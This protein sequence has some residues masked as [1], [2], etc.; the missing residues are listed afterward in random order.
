MC[1]VYICEH[2]F[3]PQQFE[4]YIL[5]SPVFILPFP[6]SDFIVN[7]NSKWV[8]RPY[9]T[10]IV[11]SGV[12]LPSS[13]ATVLRSHEYLSEGQLTHV[14]TQ[15]KY[16]T[17]LRTHLCWWNHI[18]ATKT[19]CT[20][21]VGLDRWTN[22]QNLRHQLQYGY[23]VTCQHEEIPSSEPGFLLQLIPISMITIIK[24]KLKFRF[25]TTLIIGLYFKTFL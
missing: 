1:I 14:Y 18:Q 10:W 11:R 17:K 24:I 22:K 23:H 6:G 2:K 3:Q 19:S 5:N 16:G 4:V 8:E 25:L 13:V 20:A 21:D 15:Y 9:R 12:H 7:I